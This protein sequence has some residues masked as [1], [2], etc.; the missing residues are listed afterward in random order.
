MNKPSPYIKSCP[1]G[2][3][4]D[5]VDTNIILPEGCLKKCTNCF[6]F[7][8][9]CDEKQYTSSTKNEFDTSEGTWP[10]PKNM[11]RMKRTTKKTLG[12]AKKILQQNLKNLK[13]LDIGCSNGAFIFVANDTIGIEC[14]GVE[15]AKNAVTAAKKM[16]LH[17]YHGYLKECNLSDK[18]Y[19]IITLFE[20]I[21]HLKDPVSLLKEC[22]RL[23]KDN[24]VIVIRTANTDCWTTKMLKGGWHYFSINKH[25]G[26]ISFFCLKSI[27]TLAN[28]TGF[29][30]K[31]TYTHSVSLSQEHTD[32][33]IK[34]R[35]LKLISELLN[36]PA[37]LTKNGEEMEVYL[38]KSE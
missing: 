13:L 38:C 4:K 33:Y 34:Y 24:G 18:M 11:A 12:R 5:I 21:E 31:K 15:P 10:P 26:H 28:N 23:L 22:R 29:R 16:G 7:F 37:K 19:D 2:C 6:H 20:V 35:S 27:K 14:E 32:S 3:T 25:G 8:S 36:L 30:I 17:V 1:I 9:Q